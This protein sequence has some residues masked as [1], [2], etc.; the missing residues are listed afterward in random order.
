MKSPK[1]YVQ[2]VTQEDLDKAL[3]YFIVDQQ[4]VLASII[5]ADPLF[6]VEG[7]SCVEKYVDSHIQ[8][9]G[10]VSKPHQAGSLG[11]TKI[12]PT[13]LHGHFPC[14]EIPAWLTR[15]EVNGDRRG[16][17]LAHSINKFGRDVMLEIPTRHLEAAQVAIADYIQSKIG[18]AELREMTLE[19]VILGHDHPNSGPMEL[20]TS[21]GMPYVLDK[22]G[23]GKTDHIRKNELGEI[24]FISS[25]IVEDYEA[26][27]EAFI[28]GV[29]KPY[30]FYEFPKDELRPK[31]K[32]EA[33]KTRSV[34]VVPMP[35]VMLFR[36][37]HLDL[38]A[39]MQAEADGSFQFCVG[40]N[41]EGP[42][43]GTL[44]DSMIRI[45][46]V[47]C[48]DL[49][50]SNWD[51]HMTPQLFWAVTRIVNRLYGVSENSASGAARMTM[52]FATVFGYDQWQ[53]LSF[54]KLRGNPS[55]F[56]GTAMYNTIAHMLLFYC[57]WLAICEKEKKIQY[58]N[59][60][61][62]LNH[63]CV[64]FY[65][66]DVIASVSDHVKEWFN[67]IAVSRQYESY[68]WP[69]TAACK[70]NA[71]GFAKIGDVT[72]LKRKFVEDA[73]YSVLC[74]RSQIDKSVI[75]KLLV[76]MRV[77]SKTII[78]QQFMENVNN[79]MAFAEPYGEKFYED[80]RLQINKLNAHYG[81]PIY[82]VTYGQMHECMLAERFGIIE[83]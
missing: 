12:V 30:T 61:A 8:V 34:S 68:G 29:L 19:E 9:N 39:R 31:E 55:G 42:A 21:P 75:Y 66:D 64:R 51:G 78:P 36:K 62:Y 53:D 65:G 59:F 23:K 35:F 77:N 49:D 74:V 7:T 76:W 15:K 10:V 5:D 2:L 52:S 33:L 28:S 81:F 73:D 71:S 40:I 16:H 63:A 32:V 38:S 57:I 41:P 4:S 70:T 3:N 60:N 44:Y 17:P 50:V 26:W 20:K 43:W 83:T 56:A 37:Y 25:Q 1:S 22:A 48:F 67:P 24:E 11:K 54:R 69:T 79:A 80:L 13:H 27:D 58:M 14:N 72:F 45:S 6:C 47:N 46:G 82:F 18:Y